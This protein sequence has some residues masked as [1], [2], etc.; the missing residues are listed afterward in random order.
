MS[1]FFRNAESFATQSKGILSVFTKTLN[2]LEKLNNKMNTT[3]DE[4]KAE[5]ASREQELA[6]IDNTLAL[7]KKITNN[8]QK[9]IS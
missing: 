8:I 4:I 1:Q 2:K 3:K 9:I 6:V 5:I 7:N